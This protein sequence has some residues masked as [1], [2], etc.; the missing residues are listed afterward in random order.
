MA[1]TVK[2]MGQNF[3]CIMS[4]HGM[5]ACGADIETAFDNCVKLEE[6]GKMALGE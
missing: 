3:G 5:A 6:C 1:N 4:H 2:A